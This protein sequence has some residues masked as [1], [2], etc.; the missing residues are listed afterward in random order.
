MVRERKQP[1]P[2][3][4]AGAPEWMVTYCDC[5]TLMLTF[6]VLLF[7]FASF[8]ESAIEGLFTNFTKTLSTVDPP[9]KKDK[10]AFVSTK[11]ILPTGYFD[12]GSE[13]VTLAEGDEAREAGARAGNNLT[14]D[15]ES[16]DFRNQKVF[17]FSSKRLFWGKGITISSEGRNIL[18][19]MAS[20]L[21]ETPSRIVISENGPGDDEDSNQFGLPRAWAVIEYLTTKQGLDK[22]RFSIAADTLQK[23][24]KN[25]QQDNSQ[26]KVGRTLE[27]ILLERS[28][29]N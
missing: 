19:T 14:E 13:K 20:F 6:F 18:S 11:Q 12:E 27:I 28:I 3:E 23:D 24:L 9:V 16:A 7:S 8:D 26:V 21:K 1:E 4:P 10:S 17:L 22:E 29:Y 2:E 15:T 5:M 25:D